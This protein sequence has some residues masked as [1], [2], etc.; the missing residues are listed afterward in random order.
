MYRLVLCQG[1]ICM[2]CV[3]GGGVQLF[4]YMVFVVVWHRV[5]YMVCFELWQGVIDNI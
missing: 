2:V 5:L 1:V 3:M 4:I